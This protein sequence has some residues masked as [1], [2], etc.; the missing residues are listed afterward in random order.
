MFTISLIHA[1]LR[2]QGYRSPPAMRN[3]SSLAFRACPCLDSL[4]TNLSERKHHKRVVP[5]ERGGSGHARGP[6]AEACP[7]MFGFGR[8]CPRRPVCAGYAPASPLRRAGRA[9]FRPLYVGG[10]TREPSA[11]ARGKAV[12]PGAPGRPGEKQPCGLPDILMM[13]ATDFADWQNRPAIGAK[14][15]PNSGE[16]GRT[17]RSTTHGQLSGSRGLSSS[18]YRSVCS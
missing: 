1:L 17:Q 13:Q 5:A 7:I 9:A 15:V 12:G 2:Q 18:L 4:T 6:A 11:G 3:T 10:G 16:R 8:P 14:S